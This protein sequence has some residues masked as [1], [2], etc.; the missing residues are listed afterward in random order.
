MDINGDRLKA[1]TISEGSGAPSP[2]LVTVLGIVTLVGY[3]ANFE[4][5]WRPKG[6]EPLE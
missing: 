6:K 4:A 3:S 1:K 2:M 5:G